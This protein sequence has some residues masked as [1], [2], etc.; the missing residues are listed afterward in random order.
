[1]P[2]KP[3]PTKNKA[4]R[5]AELLSLPN[6]I[7]V[8]ELEPCRMTGADHRDANLQ[9]IEKARSAYEKLWA[10]RIRAESDVERL[11]REVELAREQAR[12]EFGTGDEA[13]IRRMIEAAHEQNTRLVDEFEAVLRDIETRLQRLGE[14]L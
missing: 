13:E 5:R 14:T 7:L 8:Y 9:R 2:G 6:E 11:A 12:A 1:M 4:S 10:E 3:P